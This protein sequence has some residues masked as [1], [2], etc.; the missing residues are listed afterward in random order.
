MFFWGE[1]LF[2]LCTLTTILKGERILL[3]IDMLWTIIRFNNLQFDKTLFLINICNFINEC[4]GQY[5]WHKPFF[6]TSS[7]QWNLSTKHL[8]PAA[9]IGKGNSTENVRNMITRISKLCIT[10]VRNHDKNYKLSKYCS[11]CNYPDQ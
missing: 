2:S 3:F 8:L 7:R 11:M 4:F 6:N 1:N 10:I 5:S 9:Y